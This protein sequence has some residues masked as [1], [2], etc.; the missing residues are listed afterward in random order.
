MGP[1]ACVDR[2]G[3]LSVPID[4]APC[5]CRSM[6]PFACANRW[7]PLSAP[8]DEAHQLVLAVAFQTSA[9]GRSLGTR[10]RVIGY[11]FD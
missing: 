11:K 1:F 8:I 2:W 4:G 10:R 7:G 5:L 9:Q 3:P 6:G